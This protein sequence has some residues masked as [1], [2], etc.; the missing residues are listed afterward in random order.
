MKTDFAPLV[1][2]TTQPLSA[3]PKK[4]LRTRPKASPTPA[5]PP[6]C[7][8]AQ[9]QVEL[10]MA[11]QDAGSFEAAA[12]A[13]SNA[14]TLESRWVQVYALQAIALQGAGQT[15][16]AIKAY[17]KALA[18]QP[19]DSQSHTNLGVLL[20]TAGDSKA[21]ILSLKKAIELEPNFHEAHFNLGIIWRLQGQYALAKNALQKA[22][23]LKPNQAPAHAQ[24]GACYQA[25]GELSE[26]ATSLRVAI[27]LEPDYAQAFH[28]LGVVLYGLKQYQQSA[29]ACRSAINLGIETAEIYLVMGVALQDAGDQNAAI[30]AYERVIDLDPQSADA[31]SNLGVVLLEQSKAADAVEAFRQAMT[32]N[33]QHL[34]ACAN[35]SIALHEAGQD[36]AAAKHFEQALALSPD[37]ADI[38]SN[39]AMVR[40]H[41][42]R[43]DQ[44]L[45]L[46]KKSADLNQNHG[47]HLGDSYSV[48][49][50]KIKHDAEQ[51]QH[52]QA[53]H[54]LPEEF[55]PYLTLLETLH[56]QTH[57]KSMVRLQGQEAQN[58]APTYNRLVH[59]PC[60]RA[61]EAPF[62]NPHLSP[63]KIEHDYFKS[64]PEVV[65]ID[66]FLAPQALAEL[67][68]F[69][70]EATVWK[71]E[72]PNGY[73]GATLKDG[74]ASSLILQI[75]QELRT[76]LPHIF[77]EHLLEQAW[78]FKYDSTMKGINVH[79][80]FAAV[81]IN[82][83]ITPDEACLQPNNGG[84]IVWDKAAPTDWSFEKY[85]GDENQLDLVS[86]N[87]SVHL[88]RRL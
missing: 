39:F 22:I 61:I 11:L 33:P 13:Y 12:Q 27:F 48:P 86:R 55:K 40:I 56:Q 41:Q 83:W 30:A 50:Y 29:Q 58:M 4:Q 69:C 26:A 79:A 80:D 31:Y 24:L 42:N 5:P 87:R 14:L 65:W 15:Q 82:F 43:L 2:S 52:L 60:P 32:L 17:K 53:Q 63:E 37:D 20:H 21:G 23:E 45:V 68:R 85:N 28:T 7:A 74:L 34:H 77:K 46:L 64:Q 81:N 3:V 62:L 44:A 72:Y 1:V 84:L 16:Q 88:Q 49:R 78:A 10:G 66:D 76:R 36:D 54:A 9:A 71:K 59:I 73:L 35:L 57:E 6:A 75:A 18:L 47:R 8:A 51:L 38:Y 67:R 70:L 25:T 19:Q